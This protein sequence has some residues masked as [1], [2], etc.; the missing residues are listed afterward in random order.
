M[1]ARS[2][3][4]D[5]EKTEREANYSA[6][7]YPMPIDV[8]VSGCDVDYMYGRPPVPATRRRK[9]RGE[10]RGRQDPTILHNTQFPVLRRYLQFGQAYQKKK[11][12]KQATLQVAYL[13]S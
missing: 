1:R 11:K 7:H 12:R 8:A 13:L 9:K 5:G 10:E 6:G 3:K 4:K 2:V